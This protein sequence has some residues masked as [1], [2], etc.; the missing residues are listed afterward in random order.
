M[1]T[2]EAKHLFTVREDTHRKLVD[3]DRNTTFHHSVAQIL[4]PASCV[5]KD[6]QLA[7]VFLTTR[8]RNPDKDDWRKLLLVLKYIRLN[9]HIPLILR[10][11]KLK[12]VK[13]WV[14]ASY[15]MHPSCRSHTGAKISLGL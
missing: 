15:A 8:V 3:E 5:S 2:P 4:F 11:D 10:V 14:E 13:W 7:V 9:I 12:I 1:E 6:I